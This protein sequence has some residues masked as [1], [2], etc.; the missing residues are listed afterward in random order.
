MQAPL[1]L[2]AAAD[3]NLIAQVLILAGLW[4]GAYFARI[5]RIQDHRRVQTSLILIELLPILTIMLSSFYSYVIAGRTTTGVVALLMI[6]HGTLGL[7]AELTG[8]YLILRMSTELVPARMRVRNFKL[9]MRALLGLWTVIVLLGFGI[10]R[11]RYV[12]P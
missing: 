8:I 11:Y 9:L 2:R 10:Y 4:V 1:S 6:V 5:Q 3:I 12:A 7:T